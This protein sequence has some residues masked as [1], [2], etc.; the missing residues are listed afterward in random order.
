ML[1]KTDL[2]CFSATENGMALYNP[3]IV[4]LIKKEGDQ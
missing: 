1:L 4:V 3:W 2:H